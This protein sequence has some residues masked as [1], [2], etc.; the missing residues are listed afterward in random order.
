MTTIEMLASGRKEILTDTELTSQIGWT[1]SYA[2]PPEESLPTRW[3]GGTWL[4]TGGKLKGRYLLDPS[5][6]TGLAAG[7]TY[8][9][10]FRVDG[11]PGAE[12][13][14][15]RVGRVTIR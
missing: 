13:E 3:L 7:A 8:D 14:M 4:A 9:I 15:T 11:G 6:T 12:N 10:W 1:P 5:G 2:F